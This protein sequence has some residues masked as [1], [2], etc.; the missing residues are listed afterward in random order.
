VHKKIYFGLAITW[1]LL[2]FFLCLEDSKDLPKIKIQNLDK[3]VHA[4]FHFVFVVIWFLYIRISK[5]SIDNKIAIKK[6]FWFSILIGIAIEFLQYFFTSTRKA[7]VLD[8]LSNSIGAILAVF[9]I[10]FWKNRQ[11]LKTL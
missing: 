2:M 6:A 1:T 3:F 5:G 11:E 4:C 7:D 8:V 10:R 9:L